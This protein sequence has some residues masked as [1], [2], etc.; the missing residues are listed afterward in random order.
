[1]IRL[2]VDEQGTDT[3]KNLDNDK[4]RYLSLTGV[5]INLNHVRGHL[6]PAIHNLKS[7]IFGG[8]P[9]APIILHR[10]DILGGKGPFERIRTDWLF[11]DK[12]DAR[13][14]AIFRDTDYRV[15][16]A[17]IDKDWMVRQGHWERCHPYHYLLEILVEK[18]VQ[19]LEKRGRDIGDIMPESR[20]EGDK[21]LQAEYDRIRREGTTYVS[22]ARIASVLRGPK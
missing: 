17:F 14:T 6:V 2:Y 19:Y 1:M 9:D 5:A 10:K 18:F 16:A 11:R 20:Q 22:A 7:E 4:H 21:L 3:L 13:V 12:F 15:I 8:D